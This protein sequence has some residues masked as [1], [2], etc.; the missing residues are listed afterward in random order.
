MN[1][2]YSFDSLAR[3]HIQDLV[4]AADGSRLTKQ[5]RLARA[6]RRFSRARRG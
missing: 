2:A 6:R 5:A 1:Y 3:T 4:A